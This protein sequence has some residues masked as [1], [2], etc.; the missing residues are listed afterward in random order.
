M[1]LTCHEHLGTEATVEAWLATAVASDKARPS[2]W[3][4]RYF[5]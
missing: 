3:P 4:K 1:G 5:L 2:D